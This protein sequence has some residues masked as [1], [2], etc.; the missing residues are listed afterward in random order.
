MEDNLIDT[1]N[2]NSRLNRSNNRRTEGTLHNIMNTLGKL[3]LGSNDQ[4]SKVRS[5]QY[6]ASN[7]RMSLFEKK[8]SVIKAV[9]Q[10]K[11]NNEWND[12]KSTIQKKI[13]QEESLKD[14]MKSLFNINSDF[15]IIWKT[16]F[17]LFNVLI[18]FLYFFKYTFLKL[19][20]SEL[21][22]QP[23]DIKPNERI[24]YTLMNAMFSFEFMV[25][26]I[27]VIFNKGSLFTYIKLPVKFFMAIPFDLE[28][29][30]YLLFI[31]FVR[32][33]LV[34]RLFT[35]VEKFCSSIIN[36]F[37]HNYYLKIFMTYLNQLFKYLLIF[38]L[39]AHFIGSV[40]AYFSDSADY[41]QSLYFTLETFTTI[42]YGDVAPNKPTEDNSRM[43][44]TFIIIIINMFI[45]V[46][47]FYIITTNIKLLYL[48]IYGFNRDTSFSKQFDS[49]VFKIQK[50][51]GRVFPKR[52][53]KSMSS[54]LIFRR[55]LCYKDLLEKYEDVFQMCRYDVKHDIRKRLF[56]F[57][58]KEYSMFFS[59]C[60][61]DF[62]YRIFEHLKPKM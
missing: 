19:L 42:G 15:V 6:N 20:K 9:I 24:C 27:V 11:K 49:L 44:A 23:Y 32:L 35:I 36:N 33:D 31:K 30:K 45:G 28:S 61:D 48:K 25:S 14:K 26:L 22:G 17:S 55:G 62:M 7:Q 50:S 3:L 41:L 47:L 57:L 12:F 59:K 52:I 54:Y 38:G 51:T 40:F 53:K 8:K 58:V 10:L 2:N 16:I 29:Y 21:N 13:N 43:Y 46:N 5:S 4:G 37:I 60:S 56:D 39:Y 1:S 18:V 34:E